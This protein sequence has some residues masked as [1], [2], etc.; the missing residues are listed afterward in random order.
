[1]SHQYQFISHNFLLG[2]CE[3]VVPSHPLRFIPLNYFQ[4]ISA[5]LVEKQIGG[6]LYCISKERKAG[7]KENKKLRS[8]YHFTKNNGI[9]ITLPLSHYITVR[10]AHWSRMKLLNFWE[11]PSP[12]ISGQLLWASV[13]PSVLQDLESVSSVI[14]IF[15][16]D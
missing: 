16:C 10:R 13:I 5:H 15:L 11:K 9:N 12:Q 8:Q 3:I 14:I 4:S 6:R 7:R 1:M 2:T